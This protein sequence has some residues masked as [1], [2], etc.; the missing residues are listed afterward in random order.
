MLCISC[1]ECVISSYY[2]SLTP[3]RNPFN[4][5]ERN[6]PKHEKSNYGLRVLLLVI[7]GLFLVRPVLI[8]TPA[9]NHKPCFKVDELCS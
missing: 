3:D 4:P 9:F 1:V 5:S 7:S 2:N 6:N 8:L